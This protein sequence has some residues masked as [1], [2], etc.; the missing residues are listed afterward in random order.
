M[1]PGRGSAALVCAL[2]ALVAISAAATTAAAK[3]KKPKK[4]AVATKV[5]TKH[6]P[7]PKKA[8]P[9]AMCQLGQDTRK[10]PCA[11]N[12]LFAKEV[13]GDYVSQVQA[14]APAG[15]RIATAGNRY[16]PYV[17]NV[18]CNYTSNGTP[19]RFGFF[20]QGGPNYHTNS[21]ADPSKQIDLHQAFE[22][23]YQE[24]RKQSA[25]DPLYNPCQP[26]PPGTVKTTIEGYEA[27][28]VDDCAPVKNS[29]RQPT[30]ATASVLAGDVWVYV[31]GGGRNF[32]PLTSSQLIPLV[33]ELIAK[34]R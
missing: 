27:F 23:A 19:Q 24:A 15:T 25:G 32:G 14:L 5:A 21:L 8:A 13:C 28:T 4:K 17:D 34:Y 26:A 12:P 9:K 16:G 20:V 10:S 33:K 7:A 3:T 31:S 2:I 22:Q 11:P 18:E 1:K 6:K 29:V 30:S